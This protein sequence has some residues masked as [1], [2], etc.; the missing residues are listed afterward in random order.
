MQKSLSIILFLILVF[1]V[2]FNALAWV[3]EGGAEWDELPESI[4]NQLPGKDSFLY[5]YVNQGTYTLNT[6]L[7]E[8][9]RVVYVFQPS[10]ESDDSYWLEVKSAPL[11]HSDD[12]PVFLGAYL[13]DGLLL[14]PD[15][16]YSNYYFSRFSDGG[17]Y[18]AAVQARYDFGVNRVF[19]LKYDDYDTGDDRCLP[20]D[21][22]DYS[23]ATMDIHSLPSHIDEAIEAIDY[24]QY[25]LVT[26]ATRDDRHHLYAAPSIDSASLGEYYGGTPVRILLRDGEWARVDICGIEGFMLVDGLT[27]GLD[28]L[29]VEYRFPYMSRL[30][31]HE[32]QEI[33]IY[34]KPIAAENMC[35]G[36][37]S[38]IEGNFGDSF[39]AKVGEDWFHVVCSDGLTGYVQAKYFFDIMAP[40]LFDE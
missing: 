32:E 19:G 12:G 37:R 7:D 15:G 24:T 3:S 5:C 1:F 29:D 30:E 34:A 8:D 21:W 28:M 40:E 9:N 16:G 2:P 39:L 17:W 25:A 36:V 6:K 23:L 14:S 20:G 10:G 11:P 4:Q 35:I 38:H 18:L 22:P 31:D 26:K 27:F 33:K 13:D